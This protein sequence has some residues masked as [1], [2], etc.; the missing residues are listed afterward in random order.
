MIGTITKYRRLI[1]PWLIITVY[2]ILFLAGY[3]IYIIIA[4]FH[5]IRF[6]S[7]FGN[8]VYFIGMGILFITGLCTY[9]WIGI[10]SLYLNYQKENQTPETEVEAVTETL[11]LH[12][13]TNT[14][15]K[16]LYQQKS[17]ESYL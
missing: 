15:D 9:T 2:G 7:I 8:F 16:S 4:C 14:V 5:E 10:L 3:S 17:P 1:L 11:H 12:Q 13:Q 6:D